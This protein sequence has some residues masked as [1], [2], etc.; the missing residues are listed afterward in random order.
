MIAVDGTSSGT[1]TSYSGTMGWPHACAGADRIL[2]VS[3][4]AGD[5]NFLTD[6]YYN[7]SRMSLVA[8]TPLGTNTNVYLYYLVNPTIGTNNVVLYISGT[9]SI[10][11]RGISYTGASQI[12]IPDAYV[13]GTTA[14]STSITTTVTTVQNNSWL[15][16]GY[17]ND[18]GVFTAGTNTVARIQNNAFAMADSGSAQAVGAKSMVLTL[19]SGNRAG[20]MASFAPTYDIPALSITRDATSAGT[21]LGGTNHT[22]NL[23]WPHTISSAQNRYLVCSFLD[24]GADNLGTATFGG[25]AMTLATKQIY[26][27]EGSLTGY[28]YLYYM[29]NPPSGTNNVSVYVGSGNQDL[30]GRAASYNGVSQGAPEA[31]GTCPDSTGTVGTIN[32]TTL[33]NNDWLTGFFTTDSGLMTA[34]TGVALFQQKNAFV[35]ADSGSAV[36]I[37]GL[38]TMTVTYPVGS[39]SGLAMALTPSSS[40]GGG[41]DLTSKYW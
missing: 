13:I 8:N 25:Q 1:D 15:V 28:Q 20:V 7:N 31:L 41:L 12:D 30:Y 11:G 10:Y 29:I 4:I 34:Q 18:V 23:V 36:G 9:H 26:H 17:V 16:G 33:T 6:A 14:S 35:I 39:I 38:K 37:P 40:S 22:L 3:A 32:I 5:G 19:S 2:W 27:A 21:D 24:S